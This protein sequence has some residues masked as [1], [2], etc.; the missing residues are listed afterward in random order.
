MLSY[1]SKCFF[2]IARRSHH[3]NV[4]LYPKQHRKRSTHHTLIFGQHHTHLLYSA[5]TAH[6]RTPL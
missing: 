4:R 3:F 6:A 2:S 1:S 5:F